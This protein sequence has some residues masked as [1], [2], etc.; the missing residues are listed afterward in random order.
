MTVCDLYSVAIKMDVSEL[1]LPEEDYNLQDFFPKRIPYHLNNLIEHRVKLQL[2]EDTTFNGGE[3]Q[4]VNTCMMLN[5][6]LKGAKMSMFL[7]PTEN[8]PLDFQ[9]GG[10]ISSNY[11]GRVLLKL[12][13][14]SSKTVKLQ[15][16]ATV[17]YIVM[18]PYSLEMCS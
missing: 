8:M 2:K 12:A 13:N 1:A 14:N 4:V 16:G 6:K 10:Y 18:T 3:I 17:G 15:S 5:G 9:S 11:K 7:I